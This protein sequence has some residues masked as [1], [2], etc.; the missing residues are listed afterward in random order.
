MLSFPVSRLTGMQFVWH[1]PFDFQQLG[2]II[3]QNTVQKRDLPHKVLSSTE[4]KGAVDFERGMFHRTDR[5]LTLDAH[6][7]LHI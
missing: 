4:L 5:I 6:F 7:K 1:S 2:E 3:V